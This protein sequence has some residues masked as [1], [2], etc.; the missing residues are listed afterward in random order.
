MLHKL[1]RGRTSRWLRQASQRDRLKWAQPS[2]P[3]AY[4]RRRSRA[5]SMVQCAGNL[6]SPATEQSAR[7]PRHCCWSCGS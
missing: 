2:C 5:I 7:N 1:E 6:G 4:A 3:P